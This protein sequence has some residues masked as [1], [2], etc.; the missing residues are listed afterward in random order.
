MNSYAII[1]QIYFILIKMS[2]LYSISQAA[3]TLPEIG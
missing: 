1:A 2:K 3:L